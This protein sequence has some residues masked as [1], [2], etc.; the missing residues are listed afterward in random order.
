[1]DGAHDYHDFQSKLLQRPA[2][3]QVQKYVRWQRMADD[4]ESNGD[5]IPSPQAM[6]PLSINLDLTTA[7]NYRCDHCIDWDILNSGLK[8]NEDKLRSSLSELADRGMKSVILIGGGEP[9]VYPR[10]VEMVQYLKELNQQ[11][12]IVSNQ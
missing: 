1:M 6:G 9:T 12:A 5:N 10:F 4:A 11:I 3:D 7:C 2:W 8:Y